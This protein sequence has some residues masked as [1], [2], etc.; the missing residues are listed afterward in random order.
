MPCIGILN[1]PASVNVNVISAIHSVWLRGFDSFI[2]AGDAAFEMR[3][4]SSDE[5]GKKH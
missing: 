1:Q 5:S 3:S 2:S 4:F